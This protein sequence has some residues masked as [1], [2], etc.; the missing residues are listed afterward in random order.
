MSAYPSP[1]FLDITVT[2][3]VYTDWQNSP[4]Y[5]DDTAAA[6]GGVAVGELYRNGNFIMVRL[7]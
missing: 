4:S 7:T 1:R 3:D 6:A 5:D 2:G